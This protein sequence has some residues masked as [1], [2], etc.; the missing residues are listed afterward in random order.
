MYYIYE[1]DNRSLKKIQGFESVEEAKQE[2]Y[3]L[4]KAY[5]TKRGYMPTKVK[6]EGGILR[7]RVWQYRNNFHDF[8]LYAHEITPCWI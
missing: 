3:R 5:P 7:L 1:E 8:V 2:L 6:N 4:V